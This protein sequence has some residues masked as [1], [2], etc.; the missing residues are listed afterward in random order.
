[1]RNVVV[2]SQEAG[3]V[4]SAVCLI[5]AVLGEFVVNAI[6]PEVI[7]PFIFGLFVEFAPGIESAGAGRMDGVH[8][9]GGPDDAQAE[10]DIIVAVEFVEIGQR[11]VAG[12]HLVELVVG[13]GQVGIGAE[14]TFP[15]G[16]VEG[17]G[18]DGDGYAA[19]FNHDAGDGEVELVAGGG[20]GHGVGNVQAV[21]VFGKVTQARGSRGGTNVEAHGGGVAVNHYRTVAVIGH[22]RKLL[23]AV[24]AAADGEFGAVCHG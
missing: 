23:D 22:D 24:G 19:V 7:G 11:E 9:A 8:V 10:V 12:H 4:K 3:V 1:M 21:V 18:I 2:V 17:G 15:E 5:G 20:L 16:R 14:G 13:D 6:G